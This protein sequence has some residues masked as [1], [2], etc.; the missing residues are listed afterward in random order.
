[1]NPIVC[2]IGFVP[3]LPIWPLTKLEKNSL[4]P[5]PDSK[6]IPTFGGSSLWLWLV[7]DR[8]QQ[9]P[10]P[11]FLFLLF[12]LSPT[13]L[14]ARVAGD[15]AAFRSEIGGKVERERRGSGGWLFAVIRGRSCGCCWF[16]GSFDFYD[17]LFLVLYKELVIWQL[18]LQFFNFFFSMSLRMQCR[19]SLLY[20]ELLLVFLTTVINCICIVILD[21]GL[22]EL[23]RMFVLNSK[24]K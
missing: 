9:L 13:A 5:Q 15:L 18:L 20:I 19:T 23:L 12:S 16:W 3:K 4:T 6:L 14:V 2:S 24:S 7:P 22:G 11:S 21:R 17:F 1:M 8:T 10:L